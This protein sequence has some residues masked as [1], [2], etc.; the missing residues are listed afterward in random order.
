MKG[1]WLVRLLYRLADKMKMDR[2]TLIS[3]AF[4]IATDMAQE[5]TKGEAPC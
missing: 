3:M 5:E 1:T 4:D 2:E